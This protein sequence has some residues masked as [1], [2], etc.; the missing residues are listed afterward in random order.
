MND[1]LST[2]FRNRSIRSTVLWSN[3][4]I[5]GLA[6]MIAAISFAA[7]NNLWKNAEQ[8]NHLVGGLTEINNV[9]GEFTKFL[10]THNTQFIDTSE[11]L[12]TAAKTKTISMGH[13]H[14]DKAISLFDEM[15]ADMGLL[16]TGFDQKKENKKVFQKTIYKLRTTFKSQKRNAEKQRDQLLAKQNDGHEIERAKQ[17]ALKNIY[18]LQ[19]R[20]DRFNEVLPSFSDYLTAKQK[21]QTNTAL[22]NIV[23]PSKALRNIT[24]VAGASDIYLQMQA[25][26][27]ELKNGLH[28]LFS[29]GIG[30][31]VPIGELDTVWQGSKATKLLVKKLTSKIE[32]LENVAKSV[33]TELSLIE[34]KIQNQDKIIQ[35]FSAT[36]NSYNIFELSPQLHN[37]VSLNQNLN[38]LSKLVAGKDEKGAKLVDNLKGHIEFLVGIS[39]QRNITISNLINKSL[40][41]NALISKASI[42]STQSAIN[43]SKITILLTAAVILLVVLCAIAIIYIMT[44]AVAK[45]IDTMTNI[46]TR[47][48]AG[49]IDVV[50]GF[51]K[52]TNEI[53]KMQDAVK[54]FHSN[55]IKRIELEKSSALDF[56]REQSRQE[57]IDK[58]IVTFKDEVSSLLTSFN[59]EAD[60][61][62]A[63]AANMNSLAKTA[64]KESAE[65]KD[66]S[67]AS[68]TSIQ[69]VAS[70]AEELSISTQ[71]ITRQVQT[72]SII[73]DEG[74][75]SATETSDRISTLATSAQKIGDVV[76]LIQDIA[77]QTNLLALNATIEAA[78]AGEQGRGFAVVASEVKSLASQTSHATS[79]IAQQISDIQAAS[80]NAVD[81]I[82]SIN[83]TMA[84]VK[85]HTETIASSVTQQD[86]ATQEISTSAQQASTDSGKISN[87]ISNV[88]DTLHETNEAAS[89]ILNTSNRLADNATKLND[90]VDS[91]LKKVAAA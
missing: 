67:F 9:S 34:S 2:F 40:Q 39:K 59:E 81:A 33:S 50:A 7:L 17:I 71:E 80:D 83:D 89:A 91:F 29:K 86:A 84:I 73:V 85:D 35:T 23:G 51:K 64:H 5:T 65:A 27:G 57:Q 3:L 44:R 46:M 88:S 78:R 63:T 43:I 47:L 69:T 15:I 8:S 22:N 32:Q 42:N 12:L 4:I 14:N 87:N 56:E 24:K 31:S 75:S 49:E 6:I 11:K 62:N 18:I 30:S 58:L 16:K 82:L 79:E 37:E 72:T 10:Q 48:A 20:I 13:Q 1:I 90:H 19:D 45:P 21:E 28:T 70:A 68:T 60:T 38:T 54:V 55:A 36:L 52:R 74:A 61:M 77:E 53:G 25:T 76:N 26:I 66:R 41:T